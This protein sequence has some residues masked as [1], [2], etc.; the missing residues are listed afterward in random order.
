MNDGGK[1]VIGQDHI[2]R[3]FGH[4]GSVSSHRHADIGPLQGGR[5][6]DA[7]AGHRNDVPLLAERFHNLEFVRR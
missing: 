1:V 5:V 7:V 6:V 4:L 2:R 3:F